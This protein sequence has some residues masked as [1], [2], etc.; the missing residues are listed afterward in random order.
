METEKLEFLKNETKTNY[1]IITSETF[2]KLDKILNTSNNMI[3]SAI[4][5]FQHEKILSD[6]VML[7]KKC[8]P[9]FLDSF[10][11]FQPY[12]VQQINWEQKVLKSID[13]QKL[14]ASC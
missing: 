1:P 13:L 9:Y 11:K 2:H 4:Q 3:F 8:R 5:T 6:T 14:K 12:I 7:I 10:E